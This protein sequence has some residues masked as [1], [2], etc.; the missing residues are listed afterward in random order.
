[1]RICREMMTDPE[2]A[3]YEELDEEGSADMGKWY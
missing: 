1:M 2:L 3:L